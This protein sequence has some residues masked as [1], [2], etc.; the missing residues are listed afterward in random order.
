MDSRKA[1]SDA[2]R[3]VDRAG[4]IRLE[5]AELGG[6]RSCDGVRVA[7]GGASDP[8]GAAAMRRLEVAPRLAEGLRACERLERAG[9][10]LLRAAAA[11]FGPDRAEMLR[12]RY[13]GHLAWATIGAQFGLSRSTACRRCDVA[14]DWL[15]SAEPATVRAALGGFAE[16]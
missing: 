4:V 2:A 5:L 6:R 9:E 8:T 15:D 14:C 10:V 11:T 13:Y 12:M 3:A 7:F 16:G 1:L